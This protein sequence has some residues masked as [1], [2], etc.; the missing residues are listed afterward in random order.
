MVDCQLK[1]N[2]CGISAVKTIFNIFDQDVSRKYIQQNIFLDEQGSSLTDLQNF[3]QQHE[4]SA[5]LRILDI[6]HLQSNPAGWQELIPFIM[7]IVH[8][9]GLHYVVVDKIRG[10]KLRVLDPA[11]ANEY[12]VTL[13]ELKHMAY[14]SKSYWNLVQME[15]KLMVLCNQELL[16]YDVRIEQALTTN[17]ASTLFNKLS[18]FSYLKENFGLKDKEAEQNFLHDLLFNQEAGAL[19]KHFRALKNSET[20]MMLQAPLVLTVAP[21]PPKPD[22]I[23]PKAPATR[24]AGAQ[25]EPSPYLT[26]LKELGQYRKIWYIYIF[27]ALF[28]AMT[29][30]LSVFINQVLIDYVLPSYQLNT[31]VVFAIGLGVFK[32]FDLATRLNVSFVGIHMG[33]I[34]D[35]Y[36]L[37]RFDEKLNQYSLPYI[38]S[39]KRGD[40]TERMSDAFKLKGFFLRFFTSILVDVFVSVYS[41]GIL[42]YIDA[43]LT[44]VICVVMVAFYGWFRLVTPTLRRN[45][46]LR[47]LRKS[48]FFTRMIEKLDGIQVLKSFRIEE[49]Y[50]RKLL[51]IVNQLLKVQISNK[52]VD[53]VNVAV[54]SI[55]TMLA[56]L[57]IIVVLTKKAILNNAISL[58]QII[59]FIALSERVF[60]SLRGILSE[61]LELQENEVV[62]RRYLDFEEAPAATSAARGIED[63][64]VNSLAMCELGFGYNP[65]QLVLH[66]LSFEAVS[67]DKI[68][69]EGRNGSGK[70]TLSKVLTGLYEPAAG[71]MLLNDIDSRFYAT[72]KVKDKLVLVTNEDILFNDTIEFNIAFGRDVSPER[73]LHMARKIGLY[74]FIASKEEALGFLINENGRN[75]ST[76]QRKKIL[77]L[78][79][80]FSAA[81]VVILDEVLS[82][83]DA[84]SRKQIEYLLNEFTSKI[85]IV[86]S[87]ENIDYIQF[88]KHFS[89]ENGTLVVPA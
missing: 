43:K 9:N 88:T 29:A 42:F 76:G 87:H 53:L 6:N 49:T 15:Q 66:N 13:P 47:F 67:G 5:L 7:P 40:L 77:L 58:G 12:Y 59:T 17:N 2:D 20:Q 56:S 50:S 54:V 72:E 34:L 11:K 46:R 73:I 81:D 79:A 86:I 24:P 70:T 75:L 36:F 28:S 31:L 8:E 39:F 27:A 65:Q 74:E 30:Q 18:Y 68:R 61:N 80:L 63:F 48:E 69:I 55:I 38:Q 19:P 10:A 83:I 3:L 41:L 22:Q 37:T 21:L 52:Y 51:Q 44:L 60:S 16:P 71:R 45:E 14:F 62:L 35:K 26:L 89:L 84:A 33:N 78:R 64:S 82:G 32:L 25:P 85:L 23:A 4:F 1:N 57:L